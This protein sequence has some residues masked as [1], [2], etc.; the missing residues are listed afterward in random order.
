MYVS[1]YA[2]IRLTPR[3]AGFASFFLTFECSRRLAHHASTSI[4]R[5]IAFLNSSAVLPG[6]MKL[7][8]DSRA[9]HA[10]GEVAI[11][12]YGVQG[13]LEQ[14]R[15]KTGRVAAAFILVVGGACGGILYELVGRPFELMRIVVWEGRKQWEEGR[16]G[17]G[18]GTNSPAKATWSG[19]GGR[20]AKVGGRVA[21][22][23]REEEVR[24]STR[25]GGRMSSY[26]DLRRSN[27]AGISASRVAASRAL[28]HP[29]HV[30]RRG[31]RH[32]ATLHPRHTAPLPKPSFF[33]GPMRARGRRER[34]TAATPRKPLSSPAPPRHMPNLRTRPS[35]WTLLVEHAQRTSTLRLT[36]NAPNAQPTPVP[37]PILLWHTY[38]LA[39]Y[40]LKPPELQQQE[41][42]SAAAPPPAAKATKKSPE[43]E[44]RKRWTLKNPVAAP[45]SI[46]SLAAA[47]RWG[48]GRVAWALKRVSSQNA[49]ALAAK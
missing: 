30:R 5:S 27:S 24:R 26:I 48:S 19:G 44:L 1:V 40:L 10:D 25:S 4:D 42:G 49:C 33:L 8:Y 28:R 9:R 31:K 12:S 16:R 38:M 41:P 43:Q 39:P 45:G 32:A 22:A 21:I 46:R 7:P 29:H 13:D 3:T 47:Q 15:T 6:G 2:S 14:P 36:S 18:R 37:I 20:A 17:R 35:A 23:Q 34:T 11:N